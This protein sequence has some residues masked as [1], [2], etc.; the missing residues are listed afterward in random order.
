MIDI[1]IEP[2]LTFPQAA[3]TQAC[4]RQGKRVSTVTMW[5]WATRGCDGVILE[6]LQTPSGRVTSVAA[7][8]RFFEALTERRRAGS[9]IQ[10]PAP[11]RRSASRR[12]RDSE[13]A[14]RKLIEGG[15]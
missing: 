15:A 9:R 2:P 7:I 3:A 11:H 14:E 10:A 6:S 12:Q 13:S 8:Q 5:R 4:R 1:S